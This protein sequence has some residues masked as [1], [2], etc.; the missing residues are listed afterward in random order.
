M[1]T[2]SCLAS[3]ASAAVEKA[4]S[5]VFRRGWF[6]GEGSMIEG[7][8]GPTTARLTKTRPTGRARRRRASS[9]SDAP[10]GDVFRPLFRPFLAPPSFARPPDFEAAV[11]HIAF[12]THT[13]HLRP[14]FNN[15][16]QHPPNSTQHP[17]VTT[18]GK[19]L[20]GSP[21]AE[22]ASD[23][24]RARA[25]PRRRPPIRRRLARSLLEPRVLEALVRRG[26]PSR[27]E[28]QH[29][30]QERRDALGVR[31]RVVVPRV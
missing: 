17:A 11:R 19:G 12:G 14:A 23:G 13:A 18:V 16:I 30:R 26:A 22:W 20:L 7:A 15:S 29:G 24:G 5:V 10:A 6:W 3:E 1:L 21:P 31:V 9:A 2:Q 27:E 25:A 8:L 28:V 4:L